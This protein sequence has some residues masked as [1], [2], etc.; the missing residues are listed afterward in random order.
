M[1]DYADWKR[2]KAVV[3][4]IAVAGFEAVVGKIVSQARRGGGEVGS[5][6]GDVALALDKGGEDAAGRR[7]ERGSW[8]RRG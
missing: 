8:M 3:E 1:I 2:L 7:F 4:E 5:G 6:F